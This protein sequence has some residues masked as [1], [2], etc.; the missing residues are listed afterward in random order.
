MKRGKY[1]RKHYTFLWWLSSPTLFVPFSAI[2][3]HHW[4]TKLW[5]ADRKKNCSAI[6]TIKAS[7]KNATID[8]VLLVFFFTFD[9]VYIHE[10]FIKGLILF[11]LNQLKVY[12]TRS[13]E[14]VFICPFF[15]RTDVQSYV[16]LFITSW[17]FLSLG[18]ICTP[19]SG[20][21]WKHKENT[22]LHSSQLVCTLDRPILKSTS[23]WL[24]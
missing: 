17:L 11:K 6:Y 12:V 21:A 9:F 14:P 19:A 24:L 20:N 8:Q 15:M 13:I 7:H 10:K 22:N 1:V 3:S 5:T 4:R 2:Q 16:N 23:L 18:S